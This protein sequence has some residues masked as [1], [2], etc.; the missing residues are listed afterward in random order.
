VELL[1]DPIVWPVG[2]VV[3]GVALEVEALDL[4]RARADQREASLV[5]VV[6]QLL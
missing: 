3:V 6:D 2:D 5:E 4:W 1:P